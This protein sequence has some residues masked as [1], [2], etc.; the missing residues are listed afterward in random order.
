VELDLPLRQR[1]MGHFSKCELKSSAAK[2]S[3]MMSDDEP[4]ILVEGPRRP[5][6][7]FYGKWLLA[8][9]KADEVWKKAKEEPRYKK[10]LERVPNNYFPAFG[11]NAIRLLSLLPNNYFS[12][13]VSLNCK[14]KGEERLR[15]FLIMRLLGFFSVPDKRYEIRVPHQVSIAGV[16]NAVLAGFLMNDAECYLRPKYSTPTVTYAEATALQA[17]LCEAGERRLH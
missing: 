5:S 8:A 1:K 6:A 11:M 12:T 15:W 16:K 4:C 17:R 7:E 10:Q 9:A 13:I 2:M 3:K 14:E